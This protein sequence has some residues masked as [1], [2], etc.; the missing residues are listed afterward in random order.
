MKNAIIAIVFIL[1]ALAFGQQTCQEFF[2][3]GITLKYTDGKEWYGPVLVKNGMFIEKFGVGNIVIKSAINWISDCSFTMTIISAKGNTNLQKGQSMTIVID[4][5]VGTKA[6][7]H[8]EGD[9]VS[10]TMFYIKV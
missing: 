7:F 5:V 9:E 8:Y 10:K 3:S 4:E 6:Y 2:A 1:N